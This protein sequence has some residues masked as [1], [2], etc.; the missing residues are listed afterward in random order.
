MGNEDTPSRALTLSAGENLVCTYTNEQYAQIVVHKETVPDGDG[1]KFVFGEDLAGSIGDGENIQRTVKAGYAYS[2]TEA[3]P[4][5][6][7]LSS[8]VCATNEGAPV[9]EP[10]PNT[11][12]Y[13]PSAGESES[14]TFTNTKGLA[15][16][17]IDKPLATNEVNHPHSFTV[18]VET[19]ADNGV[20]WQP[21]NGQLVDGVVTGAGSLTAPTCT[22]DISGRCSFEI[23]SAAAGA[24]TLEASATVDVFG[25]PTLV[26]LSLIHISEPTRPY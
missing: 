3:L 21:V 4:A 1:Q 20:S 5:G 13:F 18:L 14:C 19:S 9:T 25:L 22:T 12:T 15:R 24:T 11:G 8:I 6:W 7:V 2:V 16:I 23:N 17:S 26:K 10:S